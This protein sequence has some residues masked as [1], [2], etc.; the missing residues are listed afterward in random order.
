M[1]GNQGAAQ[2]K[3]LEDQVGTAVHPKPLARE[4]GTYAV[5]FEDWEDDDTPTSVQGKGNPYREPTR[6]GDKKDSCPV[7]SPKAMEMLAKRLTDWYEGRGPAVEDWAEEV[8]KVDCPRA[9]AES[10]RPPVAPSL[11]DSATL[12]VT[13]SA[14]K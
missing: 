3:H 2:K 13:R 9:I 5:T 14:R 8:T 7:P 4:S 6:T 11:S 10:E 1:E 12:Q